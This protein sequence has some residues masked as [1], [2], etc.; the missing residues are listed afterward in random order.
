MDPTPGEWAHLMH[1]KI[2]ANKKKTKYSIYWL[3]LSV[4]AKMKVKESTGL[5]LDPNQDAK[6]RADLGQSKQ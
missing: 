2:K 3:L 6:P 5:E 1:M 4:M